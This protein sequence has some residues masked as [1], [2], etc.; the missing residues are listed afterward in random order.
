MRALVECCLFGTADLNKD[1][2]LDF[3]EYVLAL[4]L[5][6]TYSKDQVLCDSVNGL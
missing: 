5:I 4:A 2:L 1:G 6:G 3:E